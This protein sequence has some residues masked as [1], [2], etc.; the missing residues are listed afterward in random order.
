MYVLV[1]YRYMRVKTGTSLVQLSVHEGKNRHQPGT[2]NTKSWYRN[3]FENLLV[4]EIRY[5]YPVS[6]AHL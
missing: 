5:F 4:R 3:D 2:D 1:R 6:F